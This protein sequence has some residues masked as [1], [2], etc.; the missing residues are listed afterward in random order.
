MSFFSKISS[1]SPLEA[2]AAIC[3]HRAVS[4]SGALIIAC[5]A[6]PAIG[7]EKIREAWRAIS[8]TLDEG[9]LVEHLVAELTRPLNNALADDEIDEK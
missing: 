1:V 9:N 2:N 7:A 6:T 5:N 4:R 8:V 3:P